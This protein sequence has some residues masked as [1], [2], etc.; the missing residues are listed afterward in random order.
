MEIRRRLIMLEGSAVKS[1]KGTFVGDGTASVDVQC[2]FE[3]DIVLILGQDLYQ[4]PGIDGGC[5][6]AGM[7][8]KEYGN[9]AGRYTTATSTN[10]GGSSSFD[11]A[12]IGHKFMTYE[13][14]ILHVGVGSGG[15]RSFYYAKG[16]TYNYIILKL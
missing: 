4:N 11:K 16:Y 8:V 5:Y 3:P 2:S 12:G 15:N 10:I 7:Y 6:I 13:D 1:L 9:L 14:G